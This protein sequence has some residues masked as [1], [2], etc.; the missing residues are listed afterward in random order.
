MK[1]V[2]FFVTPVAG[3]QV[4]E[5][6]TLN[7]KGICSR[8]KKYRRFD[9][10]RNCQHNEFARCL[11]IGKEPTILRCVHFEQSNEDQYDGGLSGDK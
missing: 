7:T 6:V 5:D 4:G 9:A 1:K 3:V 2:S 10:E 11:T 8:C